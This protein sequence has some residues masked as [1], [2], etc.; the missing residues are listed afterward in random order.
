MQY[1]LRFHNS[2]WFPHSPLA[3]YHIILSLPMCK[4]PYVRR[5]HLIHSCGMCAPYYIGQNQSILALHSC[6]HCVNYYMLMRLIQLFR[7]PTY[8]CCGCL[9]EIDRRM[10]FVPRVAFYS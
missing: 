4:V 3:L 2:E 1:V 8:I 10:D 6:W 7:I 9:M 5:I